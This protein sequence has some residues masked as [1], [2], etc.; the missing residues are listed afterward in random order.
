MKESEK[1]SDS[2]EYYDLWK[3]CKDIGG[4]D[5]DR[6]ITI[7]TWLLGSDLGWGH[8]FNV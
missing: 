3:Y 1:N 8:I 7:V 5:K 2:F 4:R 6:M